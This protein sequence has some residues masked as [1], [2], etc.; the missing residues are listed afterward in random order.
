MW[1]RCCVAHGGA[2]RQWIGA[3]KGRQSCLG[4]LH[5]CCDGASD[6][7]ARGGVEVQAHGVE[8]LDSVAGVSDTKT[9]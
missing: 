8:E 9:V 1:V 5:A 4:G 7:V 2:V 6:L 3:C